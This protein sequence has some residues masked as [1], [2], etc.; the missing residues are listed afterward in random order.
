MASDYYELLGVERSANK[1]EIK[2]AF[3][4]LARQF[5]PDVNPSAN[6]EARFKEL[7]EAYA[8]LSDDQNAPAMTALATRA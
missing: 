1:S 2:S 7:N 4:K 5:H 3:R 8:V 6:A